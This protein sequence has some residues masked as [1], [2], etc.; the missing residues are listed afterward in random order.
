MFT[1]AYVLIHVLRR[2]LK[3]QLP[4]EVWHFGMAEL[5]PRMQSLLQELDVTTVDAAALVKAKEAPIGDGW[6]LKSFA[7]LWSRFS[8]ILL[9]DADQ[10]P[11]IDPAAA[12]AW[13]EYEES[14][15]VFWPDIIEIGE[16]NPIWTLLGR[17]PQ[18]IRSLESGQV[19]VDKRRHWKALC[20]AYL[21]NARAETVYQLIYGD[22]DTFLFGWLVTESPYSLVPHLP[23]IDEFCLAQRD[24]HGVIFTQH[25]TN[26]KWNY[27]G[28]QFRL[29][30]P[31]HEEASLAAL[32]E[33]RRKWNGHI[34]IPAGRSAE[35][36]NLEKRLIATGSLH[37]EI[38]GVDSFVVEFLPDGEIGIG[39]NHDLQNWMVLDDAANPQRLKL[40]ILNGSTPTFWLVQGPDGVWQGERIRKPKAPVIGTPAARDISSSEEP[41]HGTMLDGFL[42]AA[43]FDIAIVEDDSALIAA[44]TLLAKIEPDVEQRLRILGQKYLPDTAHAV[45]LLAIAEAVK[46]AQP[47]PLRPVNKDAKVIEA[48][49]I[50]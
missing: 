30:Q 2:H 27:S 3:C 41:V 46:R 16:S 12:F 23:F 49:Y 20:A 38:T 1:N 14:G 48:Y 29:Q 19:L 5:S 44:L 34:F 21:L 42:A 47:E 10:I 4:I 43:N 37:L 31:L 17:P 7:L 24:F 45:R 25:R 39:R 9:L 18:R 15:A 26:G 50:R 40:V 22:K 32:G 6:Q 33:L 36:R 28:E 13:K 35:A 8:E 11:A